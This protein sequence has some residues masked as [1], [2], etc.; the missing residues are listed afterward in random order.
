MGP[1]IFIIKFLFSVYY[2]ILALR[3]VLPWIPHDRTNVFIQPVYRV[4]DPVLNPIRAGLPPM[5]IGF[6]VSPFIA[7]FLFWLLQR[8]IVYLLGG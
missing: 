6:D 5:K 7:I 2:I 1:L 8:L 3:A 4:T